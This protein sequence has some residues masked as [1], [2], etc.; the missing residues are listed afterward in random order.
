MIVL[1]RMFI[2]F[3]LIHSFCVILSLCDNDLCVKEIVPGYYPTE[4]F[5]KGNTEFIENKFLNIVES[6]VHDYCAMYGDMDY[7]NQYY[8][9]N[10]CHTI[11]VDKHKNFQGKV[12]TVE[13]SNNRACY[14]FVSELKYPKI[15][16]DP[17]QKRTS[18]WS[19]RRTVY[20]P[21]GKRWYYVVVSAA[22]I[23]NKKDPDSSNANF[24]VHKN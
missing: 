19:Y 1:Q 5:A 15:T 12:T 21:S 17:L 14:M 16:V 23:K 8:I 4:L 13:A 24:Y 10:L 7:D 18:I 11:Y 6:V 2:G 3:I 9:N 20:A 22:G